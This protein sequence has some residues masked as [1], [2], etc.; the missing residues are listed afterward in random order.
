VKI[1]LV[2]VAGAAREMFG[3]AADEIAGRRLPEHDWRFEVTTDAGSRINFHSDATAEHV[4][5]YLAERGES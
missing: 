1:K 5:A 2:D 3:D 4:A